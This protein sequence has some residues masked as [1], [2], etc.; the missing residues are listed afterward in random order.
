MVKK[1]LAQHRS[2]T[3]LVRMPE[4]MMNIGLALAVGFL[5]W[6]RAWFF[7]VI[8]VLA[9]E[10]WPVRRRFDLSSLLERTPLII[11]GSSIAIII[12]IAPKALTQLTVIGFY[13]VWRY[14]M[15]RESTRRHDLI[16]T[17]II[18][19]VA[20]QAIFLASAIWHL[21]RLLVLVLTWATIYGLSYQALRV[22][23]EVSAQ[24]MAAVWA[25]IGTEIA[26]LFLTW[27]V[28]YILPDSYLI[29]PQ[30]VVVLAALGYCFGGILMSQRRGELS[31]ARLAEYLVIGAILIAIVIAGTPWRGT[32]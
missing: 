2:K 15:E 14:W 25:L 6:H 30:A 23:G 12:S 31:R 8:L 10:L 13:I 5:S 11:M 9:V 19:T 3:L 26:W 18:L 32:V 1:P 7:A 27:Q 28:S 4:L 16:N 29:V 24:L 20:F 21:P 17:V 22:R